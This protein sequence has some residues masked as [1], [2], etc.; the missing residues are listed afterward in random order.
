MNTA[1][2]VQKTLTE[3]PTMTK[4]QEELSRLQDFLHRMEEAG[5]ARKREYDIPLV[6]T[7]GRSLVV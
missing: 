4:N 6:D 7:I 2:K 1:E 3:Y 5:V